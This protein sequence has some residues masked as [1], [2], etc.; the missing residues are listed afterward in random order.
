MK[1]RP[2]G[3]EMSYADGRTDMT[4]LSFF[5]H[6]FV[7]KPKNHNTVSQCSLVG[8]YVITYIHGTE[9]K[10]NPH[11][12]GPNSPSD[13][14]T[15]VAKCGKKPDGQTTAFLVLLCGSP[16][17]CSNKGDSASMSQELPLD[18]PQIR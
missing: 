16:R 3:A 10:V 6:N 9:H 12:V 11:S 5:F 2:V 15:S 17:Q 8:R 4:K 18:I 7:N 13:C 14:W 1:I